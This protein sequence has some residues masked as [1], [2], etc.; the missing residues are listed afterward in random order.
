[1]SNPIHAHDLHTSHNKI[2]EITAYDGGLKVYNPTIVAID[3]GINNLETYLDNVETLLTL[4]RTQ[5]LSGVNLFT[6]GVM[7]STYSTIIDLTAHRSVRIYGSINEGS[8]TITATC[9]NNTSNV[10]F[11]S[12]FAEVTDIGTFN[13][14]Y[15]DAPRY[16]KIQNLS[17]ASISTCFLEYMRNK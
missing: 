12:P 3:E 16:L 11:W 5:D 14:Y 6:G 15:D 7:S 10:N 17:G 1:M 9:A 8:L 13:L 2:K 4:D